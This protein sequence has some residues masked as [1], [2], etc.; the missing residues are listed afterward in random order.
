MRRATRLRLT[1]F[2]TVMAWMLVIVPAHAYIDPASSS[3]LL[4]GLV[5]GIAAAG[6]GIAMFWQKIVSFFSRGKG[7]GAASSES[8]EHASE[9]V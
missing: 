7:T 9:Q 5:A 1:L 8:S 3:F 4:S 6:T 2:L